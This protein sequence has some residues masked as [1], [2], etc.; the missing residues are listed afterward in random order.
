[1]RV[2]FNSG[3][4]IEGRTAPVKRAIKMRVKDDPNLKYKFSGFFS[5][6]EEAVYEYLDGNF[7]W[8][9]KHDSNIIEAA[10]TIINRREGRTA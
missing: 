4:I 6:V 1:M 2:Y 3:E 7:Y 5:E 10:W 8:F 9:Y